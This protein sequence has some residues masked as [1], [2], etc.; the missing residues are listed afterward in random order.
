[1]N[2]NSGIVKSVAG[3]S[4]IV[5]R[6]FSPRPI[7]GPRGRLFRGR[8]SSAGVGD[9]EDTVEQVP[10]APPDLAMDTNGFPSGTEQSVFPSAVTLSTLGEEALGTATCIDSGIANAFV[11]DAEDAGKQDQALLR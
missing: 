2:V 3:F 9:A 6:V 8:S 1:M 7:P 5:P 11:G 4:Q 10:E